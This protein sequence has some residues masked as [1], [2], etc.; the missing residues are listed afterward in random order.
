MNV[1]CRTEYTLAGVEECSHHLKSQGSSVL[2]GEKAE[3]KTNFEL[4]LK[5]LSS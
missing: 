1:L 5:Y 4:V 2:C 3:K